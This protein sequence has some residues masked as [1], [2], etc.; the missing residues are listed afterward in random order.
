VCGSPLLLPLRTV[1]SEREG[2]EFPGLAFACFYGAGWVDRDGPAGA[3]SM[4][5]CG[6][7]AAPVRIPVRACRCCRPTIRLGSAPGGRAGSWGPTGQLPLPPSLALVS[8]AS[9]L[10]APHTPSWGIWNVTDRWGLIGTWAYLSVSRLGR[11]PRAALPTWIG[12]SN[13]RGSVATALPQ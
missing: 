11:A 6:A 5:Q 13:E 10:P 7:A 12:R 4:L 8:R 9:F 2:S 3:S 1:S